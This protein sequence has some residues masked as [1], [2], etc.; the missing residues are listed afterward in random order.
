M[1]SDG[2]VATVVLLSVTLSLPCFLYGAYYIIETEPVTW[3]VLVHHLK[4]VTT[5]L[6][7]TTVPMVFWMIPRLPDQLG[8]L[9][10]VHAMLGLQAYALLAFGGTGIVR[11]FRAKREHDLYNEYDEDL[12]LDEIGDETF[13]H[14]RSRLRIGVFGYV[15]FW[16]LAYLVGIA[17]YALRYV[18]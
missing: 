7:L 13:S 16:L 11:I 6:V 2:L 8:G 4:F 12:L 18:A 3:D 17:R 5:G 9:S 1:V 15:I 14:W 10:A